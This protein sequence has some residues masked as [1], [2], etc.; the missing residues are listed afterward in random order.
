MGRQRRARPQ[1]PRGRHLTASADPADLLALATDVAVEAGALLRERFRGGATALGSKTTPTDLVSEA[2]FAAERLIRT[3]LEAARPDDAV[4]GEE[5]GD[6]GDGAQT[7]G[8]RWV[9]DPLDGTVNFLFGIA[10]W[11]V[12]VACEDAEGALVGV[13]HD[14]LRE[15][16]FAAS[17]TGEPTVNGAAVQ[18]SQTDELSTA[19]IATGFAYDAEVRRPQSEVITRLLPQVRDIRRMGSAALDL[20]WTACGR[21]DAY[22]ERAVEPWDVA[23]GTLICQRAGLEVRPLEGD[24]LPAG[25]LVAP[26]G[27]VDALQAIVA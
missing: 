18:G 12:S 7:S 15:E 3:Q 16:T 25:V 27:L 6:Q 22:Y 10:Q 23:A 13:I 2:D 1:A 5:G 19:L 26:G 17:R 11:A 20:A 21:Y 8:L 14:P 4:L 9:V 24:E